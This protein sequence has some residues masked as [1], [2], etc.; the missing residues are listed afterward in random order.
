MIASTVLLLL[1]IETTPRLLEFDNSLFGTG[2]HLRPGASILRGVG[3]AISHSFESGG[4]DG[5]RI[6]GY[7]FLIYCC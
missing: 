1:C 2:I 6:L 3:R 5:L 4:V 7:I